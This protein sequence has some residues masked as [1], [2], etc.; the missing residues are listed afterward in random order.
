MKTWRDIYPTGRKHCAHCRRWRHVV[1]F[2]ARKW[3]DLERTI[4]RYFDSS[5]TRCEN[6][7]SRKR[8]NLAGPRNLYIH[9]KPGSKVWLEARRKRNHAATVKRRASKEYREERAEYKRFW[10]N[11]K[12]GQTARSSVKLGKD[13]KVNATPLWDY[14][15]DLSLSTV[16]L[17][18]K[19]G[20][21]ASVFSKRS[22][23]M[24]L[25]T[26]DRVLTALGVPDQVYVWYSSQ[27]A[28]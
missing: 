7:R 2:T 9:G 27:L 25:S 11:A 14:L 10:R 19:T 20:V 21:D 4:P 18:A 8:R 15:D 22:E 6:K 24:Q 28:D 12:T 17:A 1:D 13:P 3:A 23:R 16:D 5:C 26:V